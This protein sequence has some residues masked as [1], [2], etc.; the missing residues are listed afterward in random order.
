LLPAEESLVRSRYQS[1]TGGAEHYDKKLGPGESTFEEVYHDAWRILFTPSKPV[2]QEVE[3]NMNKMELVPGEFVA[4]HLRALYGRRT[5]ETRLKETVVEWTHNALNCAS[6]LRPGGPFFFASDHPYA[7]EVA[8]S[9]GVAK[10]TKIVARKHERRPH[11][12]E[13]AEKGQSLQP[14]DYYDTFV[15][16]LL[17]GMGKCANFNRGGFGQWGGLIGFNS[18]C[19]RSQKTSV[20]GIGVMC[21][22]TEGG[23][24]S[25]LDQGSKAPWFLD[26]LEDGEA[27]KLSEPK[28][29]IIATGISE[30]TMTGNISS[31][32]PKWMT[33]DYFAWRK[34]TR[35]IEKK[36]NY[37][38]SEFNKVSH[39]V[40]PGK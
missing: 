12:F 31:N 35:R 36:S 39:P 2:R 25:E 17:I 8:Q 15:D 9:Y 22:W 1:V 13:K 28:R 6:Q 24:P 10:S 3:Q 27:W 18:S 37:W 5:V 32:L 34:K 21:N 16:L 26:P 30:A 20:K 4:A 14:S 38:N 29:E 11:H 7:I 40:L 33:E 19:V 23:E